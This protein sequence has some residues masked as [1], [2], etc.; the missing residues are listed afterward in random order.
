MVRSSAW[1]RRRGHIARAFLLGTTLW[2][3]ACATTPQGEMAIRPSPQQQPTH[4][5]VGD[6]IVAALGRA[7]MSVQW[8][9]AAGVEQFYAT[10]P[11]LVYPWPREVWTMAPPTVFWI[12]IRNQASEDFQFDPAMAILVSQTGRREHPIL[13]EQLYERLVVL[14]DSGP[15]LQSLQATLFTRFVVVPRGG[16]RDGLLIF[17]PLDP[18]TKH[19]LLELSSIFIGGRSTPGLFEFQVLWQK[20]E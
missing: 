7:T 4:Q 16:Q 9:S 13:Y 11:G 2:V 19:L 6:A 15:R 18:G 14:E 12:R 5:V 20:P 17:P 3:A 10:K 1:E 8:L